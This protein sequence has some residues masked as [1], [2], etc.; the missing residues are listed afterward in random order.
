MEVL[1]KNKEVLKEIESLRGRIDVIMSEKEYDKHKL[2]QI[3]RE[4]D[5]LLREMKVIK[6]ITLV[7][8]QER[9]E[10]QIGSLKQELRQQQNQFQNKPMTR[11]ELTSPADTSFNIVDDDRKSPDFS[12]SQA[13][14][15]AHQL[16]TSSEKIVQRLLENLNPS[17]D[18]ASN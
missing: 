9:Y 2:E 6:D 10:K 15:K 8:I 1:F 13:F 12:R 11:E 4:R 16:K 18:E 5:E 7:D 14:S 17:L 3:K